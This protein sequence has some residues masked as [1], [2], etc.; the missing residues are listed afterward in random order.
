MGELKQDMQS[1]RQ[2]LAMHENQIRT[3]QERIEINERNTRKYNV[4]IYG[5][6]FNKCRSR[7]EHGNLVVI[8][9]DKLVND[10]LLRGLH[11]EEAR[12]ADMKAV[13]CHWVTKTSKPY[14]ILRLDTM[15][16][17]KLLDSKKRQFDKNY[18]PHGNRIF[19]RDDLTKVN[20]FFF[21]CIVYW[22]SC[23]DV[24][25]RKMKSY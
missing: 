17:K 8:Q 16:S 15:K 3:N 21:I 23:W 2:Q 14:I 20:A 9:P 10:M 19:I 18:T 25:D 13:A 4:R 22:F 5:F 6:D 11:L 1:M 7:D 12:V 24:L